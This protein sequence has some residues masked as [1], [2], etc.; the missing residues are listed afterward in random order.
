MFL[1][2]SKVF[3]VRTSLDSWAKRKKLH[4]IGLIWE[5]IKEWKVNLMLLLQ[6]YSYAGVSNIERS[7][8]E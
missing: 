7:L 2:N 5:T 3:I 6:D 4:L 8:L 1:V